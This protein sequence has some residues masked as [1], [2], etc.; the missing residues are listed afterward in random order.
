MEKDTDYLE[1]IQA[2]IYGA[3]RGYEKAKER[4]HLVCGGNIERRIRFAVDIGMRYQGDFEK[5][6]YEIAEVVGCGL[7][8]YEAIPAVFGFIAACKGKAM[9]S[10]YM[11]INCGDDT[12]TIACMIGFIVGALNGSGVMP[13]RHLALINRI[14]GFDLGKMAADIDF[15]VER[16]GRR[17]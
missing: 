12:D 8:A 4:A 13:A 11:G 14:N 7:Y 3:S 9:E 15:F 2:G 5:V 16:I 6:L 10:L 1:V 17:T